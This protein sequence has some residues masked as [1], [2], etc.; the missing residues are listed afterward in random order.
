MPDISPL[1]LALLAATGGAV[2]SYTLARFRY[3]ATLHAM[4]QK[5]ETEAAAAQAGADQTLKDLQ[6]QHERQLMEGQARHKGSLDAAAAAAD[7]ALKDLRAQHERLLLEEQSRHRE[8]FDAA[9]AEDRQHSQLALKDAEERYERKLKEQ[10]ES[11][12]SVTVH[13]F[14]DTEIEKGVFSKQHKVEIGYKYQLFVQGLPCFEP[15]AVVVERSVHKEVNEETIEFFKTKALEA[16]EA[17]V[18]IKSGGVA[19]KVISVARTAIKL[20]K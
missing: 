10:S 19:S 7:H 5:H 14:V 9:R 12:L 6:A 8:L 13:P 4:R 20:R 15:H 1:F 17:A 3:R 2:L 11:A 16:A 18:Q